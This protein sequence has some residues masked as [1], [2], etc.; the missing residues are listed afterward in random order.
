[1]K[2]FRA[3]PNEYWYILGKTSTHMVMI[4]YESK[5][6]GMVVPVS[7]VVMSLSTVNSQFHLK[8]VDIEIPAEYHKNFIRLVFD[9]MFDEYWGQMV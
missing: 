8:P 2:M 3:R 1:M 9:K 5:R 4:S 6:I 7:P